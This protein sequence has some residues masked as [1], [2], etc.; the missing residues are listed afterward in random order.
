MDRGDWKNDW[1]PDHNLTNCDTLK[2]AFWN[3]PHQRR[4]GRDWAYEG[5]NIDGS[6]QLRCTHCNKMGFKTATAHDTHADKCKFAPRARAKAS[7]IGRAIV[8]Q[9]KIALQ[10]RFP[11]VSIHDSAGKRQVFAAWLDATYLGH[12]NSADG[13]TDADMQR[14]MHISSVGFWRTMFNSKFRIFNSKI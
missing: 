13:T 7:L 3:K 14:R 9:R 1:Q 11:V 6:G 4:M 5:R 8:R 10:A 12:I 2:E